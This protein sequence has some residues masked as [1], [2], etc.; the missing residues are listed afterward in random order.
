MALR[1]LRQRPAVVGETE[2]GETI[3]EIRGVRATLPAGAAHFHRLMR[4]SKCEREVSGPALVSPADLDHPTNPMFCERCVRSSSP[5]TRAGSRVT[6]HSP[7]PA[8][9][10]S[11]PVVTGERPERIAA[12]ARLAAAEAGLAEL[13]ASM[14]EVRAE[15]RALVDVRGSM[16]AMI[17]ATAEPLRAALADGLDDLRTEIATLRQ[18]VDEAATG[19]EPAKMADVDRQLDR[20]QAGLEQ[21]LTELVAQAGADIEARLI[22]ELKEVG[23]ELHAALVASLEDVR[24]QIASLRQQVEEAPAQSQFEELAD[25]S[26]ELVRVQGDLLRSEIAGLEERMNSAAQQLARLVKDQSPPAG[27]GG[28]AAP[29][30]I[31]ESLDRQLRAAELRLMQTASDAGAD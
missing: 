27:A 10:T 6:E 8:P 16:A 21:K 9:P 29:G 7:A 3:Y 20:V 26:R 18:R 23:A 1:T 5:P 15:M 19:P 12:E 14:S 2:A 11:Q 31:L 17:D 13:S 22:Q 28:P 25:A 24:S 4:C 30:G